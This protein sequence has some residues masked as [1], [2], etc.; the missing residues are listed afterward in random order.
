MKR[1]KT[2]LVCIVLFFLAALPAFGQRGNLEVDLG[3]T[4]DSFA[5]L[6]KTTSPLVDFNGEAAILKSNPKTGRPAIV[7]GGEVFL[8]TDT[9]GHAREFAVYGGVNFQFGN[10]TVAVDG[11][12]RKIY[13]PTAFEDNQYFARDKMEL[14]ETPLVLRY[15]FASQKNWLKNWFAEA[16]GAPEYHPRFHEASGS[17]VSLPNPNFDHGYFIQASVGR[18]FGNWYAKA[19]YE[20]RYFKFIENQ[21]NPN[22]LYNWKTNAVTGGVGIVF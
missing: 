4:T 3:E 2:L 12:I 18:T 22:N 6:P 7:G 13:T 21:N 8:P 19:S 11:Q 15:K 17:L 20:T 10:L 5:A 9:A 16:K 1:R 14:I